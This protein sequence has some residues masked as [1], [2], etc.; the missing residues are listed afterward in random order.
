MAHLLG[1]EQVALE[2]PTKKVFDSVTIGIDEGDRIG[3]V[4]R[5]GDGKSTL[6]SLLAGR[7]EPDSGR[8][9]VRGGVRIGML[10]QR[11]ALDPTMSVREAVVGDGPDHTWASDPRIRDVIGGL[12]GDLDWTAT[13][14]TLSGGQRRRAALAA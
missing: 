11:D 6:M 13:T 2:F 4:G 10:D 14:A 9:T 1:A 8:V 3:I 5:N 7:S 12:L